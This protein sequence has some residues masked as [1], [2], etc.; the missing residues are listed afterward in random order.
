MAT[1]LLAMLHRLELTPT[2]IN[3]LSVMVAQQ[4]PGGAVPLRQAEIADLLN[5]DQAVVSRAM[6]L[7]VRR[8]I[9]QRSGAGRGHRY[10]LNPAIAGYE[11]EHEMSTELTK[12]LAA[13]GPPPI[14]VPQYRRRP[15]RAGKGRL[16]SV[17]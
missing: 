17:A 14:Q 1:D 11:S 9:V 8:G 7:L 2:A 12:V 13:G 5:V 15:P 16:Q 6:A 10:A 4:Q 3:V